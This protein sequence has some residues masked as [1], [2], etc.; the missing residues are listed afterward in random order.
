[1]TGTSTAR[2]HPRGALALAAALAITGAAACGQQQAGG[3]AVSSTSSSTPGGGVTP[4][5][6]TGTAPSSA[7][8]SL[9]V[10]VDDGSG[11]TSTWTLTCAPDG[12]AGGDHPDAAA[13]CAAL[14]AAQQPFAPVPKDRVCTQ[15][16]GGPQRAT[17]TGT[18]GGEEVSATFERTDGCQIARWDRVAPLLQ[19]GAPAG[20]GSSPGPT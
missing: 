14:T 11:G 12:T 8:G 5:P 2:R 13:A 3:P 18:W 7:G 4:T 10:T 9:T 1:M 19:P 20:A 15:V 16:Y 6:G 17:V